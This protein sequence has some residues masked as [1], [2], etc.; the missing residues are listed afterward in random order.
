MAPPS[1]PGATPHKNVTEIQ[2]ATGGGWTFGYDAFGR[3]TFA[4]DPTCAEP[5]F[6]YSDRGDLLAV[7][8]PTGGVERYTMAS[9]T[10]RRW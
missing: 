5:R 6:S 2:L 3:R 1:G 10:S 4:K 7:H 9:V 8:D